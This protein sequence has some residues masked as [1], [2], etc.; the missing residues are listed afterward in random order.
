MSLFGKFRAVA[1]G[2]LMFVQVLGRTLIQEPTISVVFIFD[3]FLNAYRKVGTI[4]ISFEPLIYIARFYSFIE[5]LH[6]LPT[7][8]VLSILLSK[9]GVRGIV[10][11]C[12]VDGLV[13]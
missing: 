8:A 10:S 5:Q 6:Q 3:G 4:L 12:G 7:G 13:S 9:V 11:C 2:V 1:L